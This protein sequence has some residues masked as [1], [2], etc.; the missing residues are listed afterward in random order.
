[1][2]DAHPRARLLITAGPTHEPIDAV[3]YLANRSSGR[4]G[5]A[6][7]GAA[8]RRGW[9][10]T[11]LLGPVDRPAFHTHTAVRVL[12]FTTTDDLR[13]LLDTH[14]GECDVLIM[15]AAV[16]DYRPIHAGPTKIARGEKPITLRLEPTPDLLAEVAARRRPGQV[17]VGFALGPREGLLDTA[18]T[19]LLAKGVDAVVA[20][21]LETIDSDTIEAS[22]LTAD[23]R[24]DHTPGVLSKAAFAEWLLDRLDTAA[25]TP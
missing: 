22:I 19:K 5:V 20:N 8:A 16:A 1:M 18:R 25:P 2:T 15:A 10:V 7:A 17:F 21:P 23:N 12:R 14:A 13:A 4:V 9:A 24:V 6:L 3:R 11:L